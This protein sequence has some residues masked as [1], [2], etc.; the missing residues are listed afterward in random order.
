MH[1]MSDWIEFSYLHLTHLYVLGHCSYKCIILQNYITFNLFLNLLL[2]VIY[3]YLYN[4]VL[5]MLL[6]I[7][8]IENFISYLMLLNST[9]KTSITILDATDCSFKKEMINVVHLICSLREK[10]RQMNNSHKS[11]IYTLYFYLT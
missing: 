7:I 5:G 3:H 4:C 8:C 2:S 6:F 1:S 11:Y 9:L 10:E